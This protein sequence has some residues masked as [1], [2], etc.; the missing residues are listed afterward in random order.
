M[1]EHKT[2]HDGGDELSKT[3]TMAKA[4]GSSTASG[5]TASCPTSPIYSACERHEH[6]SPLDAMSTHNTPHEEHTN[7]LRRREEQVEAQ[8]GQQRTSEAAALGPSCIPVANNANTPGG[9]VEYLED[10]ETET[11]RPVCLFSG[12]ITQTK[13]KGKHL[14]DGIRLLRGDLKGQRAW[15]NIRDVRC[16][17]ELL[18]DTQFIGQSLPMGMSSHRK[19]SCPK[20]RTLS[21]ESLSCSGCGIMLVFRPKVERLRS[22]WDTWSTVVKLS[23]AE[24]LGAITNSAILAI[25]VAR[26]AKAV[27]SK[28][29]E[30][31]TSIP[32][33]TQTAITAMGTGRELVA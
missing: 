10:R 33:I 17:E 29:A 31:G 18:T 6:H 13:T 25:V 27:T 28:L 1:F 8:D 23:D 16:H 9:K 22:E 14:R 15:E 24:D 5:K 19:K 26:G 7:E 30:S 20:S 11:S 4:L 32:E 21:D 2:Q 3:S 12:L